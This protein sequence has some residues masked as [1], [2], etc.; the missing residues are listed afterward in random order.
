MKEVQL[1]SPVLYCFKRDK[2]GGKAITLS[3]LS[4]RSR[5]VINPKGERLFTLKFETRLC[6]SFKL[7][8]AS[9]CL[10]CLLKTHLIST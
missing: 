8:S 9:N 6:N 1:Y 7:Y 4:L 10:K 5:K 2:T 3:N